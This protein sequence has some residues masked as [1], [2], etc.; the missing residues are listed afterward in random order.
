VCGV[1]VPAWWAATRATGLL[2]VGEDD[3]W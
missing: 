2:L 1:G 3:L